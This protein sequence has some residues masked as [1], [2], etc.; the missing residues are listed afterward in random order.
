MKLNYGLTNTQSYV[1]ERWA[2]FSAGGEASNPYNNGR[3]VRQTRRANITEGRIVSQVWAVNYRV[4][5]QTISVHTLER[6]SLE[7]E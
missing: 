2:H 1:V 3:L 5:R 7:K 6:V 4:L